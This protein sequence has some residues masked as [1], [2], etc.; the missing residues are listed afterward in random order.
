MFFA[1][2]GPGADILKKTRRPSG[3]I[4]GKKIEVGRP[5]N[6]LVSQAP[7]RFST[8]AMVMTVRISPVAGV[9][10]PAR[11]QSS[12]AAPTLRKFAKT[13]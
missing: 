3:E 7:E 5:P 8:P 12:V 4:C 11:S 10:G 2:S 9:L 6:S 1:P 13:E